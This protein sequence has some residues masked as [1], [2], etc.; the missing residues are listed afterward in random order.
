MIMV[1]GG[2]IVAV[3]VDVHGAPEEGVAPSTLGVA[4]VLAHCQKNK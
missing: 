2:G 3:E 4:P 1:L